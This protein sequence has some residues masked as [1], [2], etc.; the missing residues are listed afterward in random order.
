MP[1]LGARVQTLGLNAV[2]ERMPAESGS[3]RTPTTNFRWKNTR[4]CAGG[5]RIEA[6]PGFERMVLDYEAQFRKSMETPK[7]GVA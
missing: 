6:R 5:T 4:R 3:G 7:T 1:P 2:I